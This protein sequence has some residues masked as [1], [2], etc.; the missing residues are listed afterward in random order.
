M[1]RVKLSPDTD[2]SKIAALSIESRGRLAVARP[3]TVGSASRIPGIRPSDVMVLLH[4]AEN[5]N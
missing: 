3:L 1:D 5:R 4:W 2:Y